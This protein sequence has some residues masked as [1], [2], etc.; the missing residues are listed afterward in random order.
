MNRAERRKRKVRYISVFSGIEAATVAWEPLGWEPVA[1]CEIDAFPSAVL[2]HR[3]PNVPNLG[4]ITK[5]DWRK[6]RGEIDII[7]GGSPC[8]SFSVAGKREGL[9]G[10]S[11]LMFEYI[12]AVQEI[13]PR[14]FIWENVPGALS[15]EKGAAFG[16]L[17]REMDALGYGLAW[18]ILDAQFF[19][20]AQRR[21]RVFL[22][23]CLGDPERAAE[24][25]FEQESLCW[26][27]P[28]SREK[29]KS[30]AAAVERGV[31]SGCDCLTPWDC[32][33]K[34]IYTKDA[35]WPS[36]YAGDGGRNQAVA[37]TLKIR[38]GCDGGG[39]GALVQDDMSATLSTSNA[40][41]LFQPVMTQYGC[42]IAGT[43]M[44]RHDSS[45]CTDRGQNVI[46]IAD[47]NAKAATDENMCGSLKVGGSAPIVTSDYIVR[48]LTPVE[49]ERLQGF[50]DGWTN[51][52]WKGKN[53]P[54]GL[55]YKAL[56][57]SMAVPVMRWIG[58]RIDM[59][60]T[61]VRGTRFCTY[62]E[63]EGND[64]D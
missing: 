63:E 55:R 17:L 10:E 51:I 33:S 22:V 57:N 15:S 3:F 4:D 20:V 45:P 38:G 59:A 44:A 31:G 13:M 30:L 19:N 28:S 49:C 61:L 53:A 21:E 9:A 50:P 1:F 43:L 7:V 60:D 34:R 29:R 5:V 40:Q 25:L 62:E 35:A 26:D 6:Y 8:Q 46:C 24:I 41:T 54:D 32:Q 16:Q 52:E 2:A 56:G 27:Y 14:Y 12:R 48:R 64:A 37:Y 47:D 42:E 36:L 11:G 18:R 23:G 39:K 58:Q